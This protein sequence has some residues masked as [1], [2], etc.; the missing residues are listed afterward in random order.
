MGYSKI[1]RIDIIN[2]KLS[3]KFIYNDVRYIS[4]IHL[5]WISDN[6]GY[7]L[8][9]WKDIKSICLKATM[10]FQFLGIKWMRV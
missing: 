8:P 6:I 4:D 3:D 1:V 5:K 7:E 10:P 9:F 2:G